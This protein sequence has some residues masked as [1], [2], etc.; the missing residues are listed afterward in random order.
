MS[1]AS[2][3]GGYG[4]YSGRDRQKGRSASLARFCRGRNVGDVVSG[5]FV[6]FETDSLGWA[7]LEG[8]ELLA[9]LPE[10]GER[11]A[12]GTPVF[13]RVE[14]LHPEVVLRMLPGDAP[15]ARLSV[16]LPSLPLS[17]EAGLYIAARDKLDA[18]LAPRARPETADPAA[19]K[20]RFIAEAASDPALFSAFA[21][22]A[23]RARS[24][25][26]AGAPAGLLF[27]QH[28]PWLC[29]AMSCVEVS[30]WNKGG[31]SIIAGG[32]LPSGD[33]LVVRGEMC[34]AVLRHKLGVVPANGLRETPAAR[35]PFRRSGGEAPSDLVGRILAAVAQSGAASVGRFSRRL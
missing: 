24:L 8:E 1:G 28:M 20:E 16:M 22:S 10:D 18:L 7:L 4:G 6:R 29:P 35:E 31:S 26:R 17:Q 14:A 3:I 15:E 19:R 2:R 23:A 32:V 33:R 13:F 9:G 12:P 27:F 21:E 30:L 11:P 34:G 5:V 25:C